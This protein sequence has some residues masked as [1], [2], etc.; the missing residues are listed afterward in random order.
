MA[1]SVHNVTNATTPRPDLRR[2]RNRLGYVRRNYDLYLILVPA[3]LYILVFNYLPLLGVSIAFQDYNMFAADNPV[4]AIFASPWVGLK[5]FQKLFQS[6]EFY[7]IF[8]NTLVISVLK[9][10]FIF[11]LPIIVAIMLNEIL[12]TGF[13]RVVQTVIYLP[14]FLS[15]AVV[16]GIFVTLLGSTGL[17]NQWLLSL[18]GRPISFL[19]DKTWFRAV[20]VITDAWKTVGWGSIIYIAAITGVDPALYEAA[21]ID[22]A[23]KWKQMWHVTLPCILPTIIMMLIL[24]V[25]RVLDAGFEQI[26]IMYHPA[27][28]DVADIIGTFVYREGLGRMNFSY[29][30]AVGLFNSVVALILVLGS[31]GISKKLTGKSIW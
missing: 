30:T 20:L 24:R 10:G 28:Y 26:F 3:L 8:R 4:S 22:G 14:H 5:H 15:W 13:K 17:V 7:N 16:S 21:M 11:P 29:G 27:V 23:G 12:H 25:S 6:P 1:G 19:V 2:S 31:N 18:G 9:I